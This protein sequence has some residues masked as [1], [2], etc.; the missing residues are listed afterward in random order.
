MRRL[1]KENRMAAVN[2][3]NAQGAI[4]A[5][6]LP[7]SDRYTLQI[8]IQVISYHPDMPQNPES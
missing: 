2:R 4:V 8:P 7:H 1:D 6:L 5:T 3:Y